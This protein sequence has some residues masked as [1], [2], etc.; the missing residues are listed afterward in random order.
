M[1]DFLTG[2][3]EAAAF[4]K[5]EFVR[6]HQ[7]TLRKVDILANLAGRAHADDLKT[8][9]SWWERNGRSIKASGEWLREHW[10]IGSIVALLGLVG[11]TIKQWNWIGPL[12][13]W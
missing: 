9:S 13:P 6:L 2:K 1:R 3:E 11:V 12:M 4:E 8:L 5:K 7:S 10:L